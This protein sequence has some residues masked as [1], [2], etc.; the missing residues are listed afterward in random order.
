MADQKLNLLVQLM[1][2]D[3]LSGHLR[4]ISAAGKVSSTG[5]RNLR[6]EIGKINKVQQSISTFTKLKLSIGQTKAEMEAASQKATK[7]GRDIATADAPTIKMQRDFVAAKRDAERLQRKFQD[8]GVALNKLRG[9]LSSAGISTTNLAADQRRLSADLLHATKRIEDQKIAAERAA[10]L[11][12]IGEGI[13]NFGRNLTLSATLPLTAF[14]AAAIRASREGRTAMAQVSAS[15]NSMGPRA[16]FSQAQL[17]QQA[18]QLMRNSLYDD[19]EILQKVTANLLTFGNVTGASFAKAQIAAVN[20]SAKLGQDLQS[21]TIQIGKAL[22]DPVKG[23]TALARVGVSFTAQQKDMIKSMVKAGNVAGAQALILSELDK[24]YGNS[25][26]AARDADPAGAMANSWGEFEQAVGDKLLPKLT[27]LIIAF[28][29]LVD[30]FGELSPAMQNVSIG[31]G[32]LL[33][34]TGPLL[35]LGTNLTKVWGGA[36]TAFGAAKT[37]LSGKGGSA[38][39]VV[40]S[41]GKQLVK[42]G[43]KGVGTAVSTLGDLGGKALT[44]GKNFAVAGAR[45]TAMA[46]RII[47]GKIGSAIGVLGNVGRAALVMGR[48]FMRAGM[49]MLANP[50]VLIIAAIVVAVGLLGYVIYNNWDKIKAAFGAGWAWIQGKWQAL[51][52]WWH[53][54]PAQ[55]GSIGSAMMQGLLDALNPVLLANKLLSIAQSGIAAFKNFFG[56]KSPSRLFMQMGGHMTAGL[57]IGIERG[58]RHPLR[59]MGRLATGV[60]GATALLTDPALARPALAGA[61]GQRP[62]S[63][64]SIRPIAPAGRGAASGRGGNSYTF[65][66]TQREGEDGEALAKRIATMIERT[67]RRKKAGGFDDDF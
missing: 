32:L 16:G 59:A 65:H 22:N 48:G 24:Q 61:N 14:G 56:I 46:A 13:G 6:E 8:Q 51:S 38:A 29:D 20:L 35:S 34:G 33:A 1:G 10:K 19:D 11:N 47:A 62:Q 17:Q 5:I 7:L 15:L 23:V 43:A 57:G 50:M 55:L 60:V 66:I 49:M 26:K 2:V 52:T 12:R 39:P 9:D 18:S 21:S 36:S 53:S 42:A 28:S 44:A 31:A 41:K 58:G 67:N 4:N 45:Y 37:V 64:L 30:K 3:K 27:P 40:A 25:A 54:L 63:E